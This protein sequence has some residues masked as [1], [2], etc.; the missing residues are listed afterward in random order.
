MKKISIATVC[1][2]LLAIVCVF[3]G[4]PVFSK[5]APEPQVFKIMSLEAFTGLI[6]W[7]FAV[8]LIVERA[9]EVVVMVFRDQQADLLDEAEN[10][11]IKKFNEA[12]KAANALALNDPTKASADNSVNAVKATLI[13]IQHSKVVYRAETKEVALL[14]GF[15]FGIFVSMAGV[16]ALH[17]L[18]DANS[19]DGIFFT[20]ADIVVTGAMLAGG[21]EG[22][23]RMANAFN[24]FMD[25][26]SARTDQVQRNARKDMTP[27]S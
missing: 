12:T 5:Q 4:Y 21:S 26:L 8:A 23:H 27:S 1:V 14:V 13:A 18:L 24:G 2:I 19:S 20:I 25:G 16:R 15:A 10:Q 9:V 22:I 6:G 7:L 11:A 17:S 3:I